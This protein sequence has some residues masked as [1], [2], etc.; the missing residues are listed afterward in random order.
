[1]RLG[2]DTLGVRLAIVF[3]AG[4]LAFQVLLLTVVFW[5]GRTGSP[6]FLLPSPGQ[7]RA[8]AEALEAAPP[9]LR[10]IIVG[11]LNS[12]VASVRLE[13][14]APVA[15]TEPMRPAPRLERLFSRYA[16]GL[17]GRAFQVQ[18]RSNTPILGAPDREIGAARPVRLLV[19]LRTG[20]VLIIE[21]KQ[22]LAVRRFLDR[23][24]IIGAVA[25]SILGLVLL[26]CLRQTARPIKA[27]ARSA[28]AFADD[29]AAPNLPLRG[30][31]EI[32]ELSAAFNG[33][34]DTIRA[35]VEDR[36]RLLAA[37]AHDMR[38]YLTRL[39]LR[40]EFIDDPSQRARAIDDLQEMSLLL[41]DT[42]TFAREATASGAPKARLVDVAAELEVL[43]STRADMGEPVILAPPDQALPA[44]CSPMALRRMLANLV[45]NAV[46]YGGGATLSARQEG[47]VIIVSVEDDGP[48]VPEEA[49][50]RLTLPFV[51]LEASRGRQ[52]GGS[53]LG[54]AIVKG[55][56][57]SQGAS[58]AIANRE[59]GGL[60]AQLRLRLGDPGHVAQ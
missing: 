39:R 40:V 31:R 3:L 47:Q 45:D 42:L 43:A 13:R 10:P 14:P 53:G 2:L 38:T 37:I 33:M 6:S 21:R 46:R 32:K 50:A 34:K 19:S 11:A 1:M 22:P 52:T 48:G 20:Q 7:A 41:D 8:M 5:P 18:A 51:R 23:A 15:S 26:V 44:L 55:L 30:V 27:L 29:L 28:H 54:L 59:G 9:E 56:A 17:G 58:L 12:D 24:V 49:L 16:E 4:A 25:A 35:L 36:T 60:R 57:D